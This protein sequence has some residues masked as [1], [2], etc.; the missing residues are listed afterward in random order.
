MRENDDELGD[1]VDD[2]N[3]MLAQI[4]Q[5]DSEL[6]NTAINWRKK[7]PPEPLELVEARDRA[8][9]AS[10]AKSEFLANMSHEI[11]TPMNGVIGMTE[12]ALDTRSDPRAARVSRHG[13]ILGR[14]HDDVINDILDFSKIEARKLE[15]EASISTFGTAWAKPPRRLPRARP[16]GIGTGVRCRKGCAG[17]GFRRSHPAAA[18]ALE[19]DRQ[20]RQVHHA[21]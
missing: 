3:E 12:L 14:L 17:D 15:L 7:S 5:R 9:A 8:Q 6:K 18:G 11:R 4:Q 13:A 21:G 16:K 1:L 20:R 19:P 10:R 2:F